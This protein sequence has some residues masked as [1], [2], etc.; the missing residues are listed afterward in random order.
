MEEVLA[1]AEERRQF[2][3]VRLGVDRDRR[4]VGDLRDRDV[5]VDEEV[6]A[7][8]EPAEQ[9]LDVLVNADLVPMSLNRSSTVLT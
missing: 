3:L 4:A 9:P 8:V 6:P 2:G 7:P 1:L 5:G